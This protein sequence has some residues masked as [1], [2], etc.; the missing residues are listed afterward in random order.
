VSS[1]Y[2]VPSWIID[3]EGKVLAAASEEN[4]S[5]GAIAVAE[6]DL[7]RRYVEPWLGDMR[8]RFIKEHRDDAR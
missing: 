7:N 3:P 4:E 1:G 6:I 8:A 2:D 5:Q